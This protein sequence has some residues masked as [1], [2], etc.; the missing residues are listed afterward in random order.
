MVVDVVLFG[1]EAALDL[2]AFKFGVR[3]G[4]SDLVRF[5]PQATY[6]QTALIADATQTIATD[7]D[8]ASDPSFVQIDVEKRGGGVGNGIAG[9]SAVVIELTFDVRGSGTTTLT[10]VGLGADLPRA[11]DSTRAPIPAVSFDAASATVRVVTSGGGY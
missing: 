11:F 3:N 6:V 5:A 8:G 4:N 1:P 10:L 2:N 9:A 7:V